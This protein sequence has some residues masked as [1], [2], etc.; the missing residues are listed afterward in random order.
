[1]SHYIIYKLNILKSG[2]KYDK[3]VYNK[4]EEGLTMAICSICGEK[5]DLS[6]VR[7]VIGHRYGAGQYNTNFPN[8]DVCEHCA[9][10]SLGAAYATG[11]EIRE[12]MGDAWY[13]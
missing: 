9:V 6:T 3:V 10:D 12:L 8:N 13:D 5:F 4:I 11:A 2:I 1:M 7:R